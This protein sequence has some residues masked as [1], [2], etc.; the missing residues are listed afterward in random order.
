MTRQWGGNNHCHNNTNIHHHDIDY[1]WLFTRCQAW[2][3]HHTITLIQCTRFWKGRHQDVGETGWR[4]NSA[5]KQQSLRC[6]LQRE[7]R[8]PVGTEE[9]GGLGDACHLSD[10][11]LALICHDPELVSH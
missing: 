7:H 5:A 10:L 3:E 1:Y 6:C 2:S 11:L 8:A 9:P 4:R